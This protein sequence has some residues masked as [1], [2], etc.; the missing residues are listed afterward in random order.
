ML[1]INPSN[2]FWNSIYLQKLRISTNPLLLLSSIIINLVFIIFIL[3][4]KII[5]WIVSVM[6]LYKK[7]LFLAYSL[8]ISLPTLRTLSATFLIT[9]IDTTRAFFIHFSIIYKI[10][11]DFKKIHIETRGKLITAISGSAKR[12]ANFSRT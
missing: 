3:I 5:Y 12:M 7:A 8:L 1:L 9:N 2:N 11:Y 4:L 6:W 10:I